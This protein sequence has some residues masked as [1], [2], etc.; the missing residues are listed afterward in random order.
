MSLTFS[1]NQISTYH[2]IQLSQLHH[3]QADYNICHFC[4]PFNSNP[5]PKPHIDIDIIIKTISCDIHIM[6]FVVPMQCCE[7]IFHVLLSF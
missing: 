4:I 3:N 5:L 1:I 2:F 6:T 7:I